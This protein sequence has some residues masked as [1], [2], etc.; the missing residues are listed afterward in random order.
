[1]QFQQNE[2][3]ECQRTLSKFTH[4]D[5]WY[6][7][8]LGIE[9]TL[10]KLTMEILLNIDLENYDYAESRLTSLLRKYKHFLNQEDQQ[11]ARPFLMLVQTILRDPTIIATGKFHQ[12]VEQSITWKREGEEDVFRM[13]FYAWLKSKIE[14][15]GLYETT[16]ELVS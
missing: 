13:N 12:Q 4:T 1:M 2:L 16:L 5:A 7:K 8:H 11:Q 6:E 14:R 3:R 10:H 9:W 15:L